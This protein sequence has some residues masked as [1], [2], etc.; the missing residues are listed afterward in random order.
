[1]IYLLRHGESLWNRQGRLQGHRDSALTAH[2]RRQANLMGQTLARLVG[3]ADGFSM[4]SSPLGRARQTA[5]LVARAMG[6]DPAGIEEEPRLREHGFGTWEGEIYADLKELFP[7]QWS[8]READKWHY[9]VPEGESY[10]LVA[11]RAGAWLE[12]QPESAKLIVVSHGLTGR[13]LRGL[14]LKATRDEIFDLTEPQDALYRLS[15]G[16]A[17]WIVTAGA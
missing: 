16:S 17:A 5:D 8:A 9:R 11:A 7:D 15:E 3:P 4:I 13:I 10:A 14:Y 6:R 12:E 1:M 2:G